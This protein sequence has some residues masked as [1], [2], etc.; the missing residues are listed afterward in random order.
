QAVEDAT[1]CEVSYPSNALNGGRERWAFI[2]PDLLPRLQDMLQGHAYYVDGDIMVRD[3]WADMN[4]DG[5]KNTEEFRTVAVVAEGRGGTHYFALE[6]LWDMVGDTAG[7]AKDRPGF[8]WMFPQPCSDEAQYFGKTLFSLSPKP[9]PIGPVLLKASGTEPSVW[10]YDEN[11]SERWVAMLS[12]GW[13]PGGEKGR[14][15]YMVDVWSGK[16]GSRKDNLLWKWEFQE[17]ASGNADEPRRNLTQG[18]VAPVA[19][20]DYGPNQNPSFDGFF[21]TAVVGDLAGQLWTLRFFEPGERDPGTGLVTNWSGGRAFSMDKDGVSASNPD[22]VLERSPFYY[23]TSLAV[24]PENNALRA[25]VG[26]GN[27]YSLIEQGAGVCRFD[28]PQMCSKLGC[29]QTQVR[30]KLT[31]GASQYTSMRNEWQDQEFFS[32]RFTPWS[33]TAPGSACGSP[34]NLSFVNAEFEERR[35]GNCPKPSGGGNISYEFA[36]TRVQCGQDSYG[37]FDCRV[38]DEGNILNMSDLDIQPSS[39][40][41]SKLGKDRFFGIWVYGGR[42]DRVFDENPTASSANQAKQYDER[43]LTDTGGA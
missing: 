43:R 38:V 13:S 29:D 24:Q 18:I 6:V 22:S 36:R 19:L 21:D 12:G 15:V 25:F 3:I 34:G 42:A 27:R 2:P 30:Y 23:L 8:R 32:A 26:T 17:N 4:G 39:T 10:R 7:A 40:T 9:P 11:T 31:R 16:V 1:T 28:N 5:K 33:G 37:V 14:G 41:L 20:A 35:V